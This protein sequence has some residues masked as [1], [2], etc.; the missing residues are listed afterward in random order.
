[1]SNEPQ[2]TNGVDGRMLAAN[3]TQTAILG[4]DISSLG[5]GYLSILREAVF[6]EPDVATEIFSVPRGNLTYTLGQITD[7]LARKV[8]GTGG[9]PYRISCQLKLEGVIGSLKERGGQVG[10]VKAIEDI[11]SKSDVMYEPRWRVRALIHA[12]NHWLAARSMAR[13]D[14]GL[15][16]LMFHIHSTKFTGRIAELDDDSVASLALATWDQ[17]PLQDVAG[18]HAAIGFAEAGASPDRILAFRMGGSAT[19]HRA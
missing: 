9:L 19:A 5:A 4:G 13:Q 16:T 17:Q 7:H 12:Y 3:D 18:L 10:M 1:M 8:G 15:T 6:V 14:V 11:F 2:V